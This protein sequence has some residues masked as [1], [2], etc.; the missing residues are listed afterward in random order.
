MFADL[1]KPLAS[2]VQLCAV[3]TTN[4]T[5]NVQAVK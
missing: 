4:L 1:A 3:L 5:E 2:L